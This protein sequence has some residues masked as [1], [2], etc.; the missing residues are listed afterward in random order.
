MSA[1]AGRRGTLPGRAVCA[2]AADAAAGPFDASTTRD[3][4]ARAG[5][6]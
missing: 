1:I 6:R 2:A 5:L 4:A 3:A